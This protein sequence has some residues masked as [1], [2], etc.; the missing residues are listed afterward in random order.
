MAV[1]FFT[2]VGLMGLLAMTPG[3]SMGGPVIAEGPG[4]DPAF[5]TVMGDRAWLEGQRE[6]EAAERIIL[7]PD[8]I[9]Q[10]SCFV[11]EAAAAGAAANVM[12]SDNVTSPVLFKGGP[13]VSPF[14]PNPPA[15]TLTGGELEE[16]LGY[17]AMGPPTGTGP[18]GTYLASNFGHNFAGGFFGAGGVCASMGAVWHFVKCKDFNKDWFKTFEELVAADPR[19]VPWACNSPARNQS[20]NDAMIGAFPPP[21]TPAVAGGMD[22]TVHYNGIFFGGN[23]ASSQ[24]IPTG[25]SVMQGGAARADHVCPTPGCDYDGSVCR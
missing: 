9:L 16:Y 20:W 25:V 1:R 13:P 6:I 10:Y 19:S 15:G 21:A 24:P 8:S 22:L 3:F 17:I 5:S 23:C 2:F 11:V 4:C 14:G 18:G 7:K 12:F